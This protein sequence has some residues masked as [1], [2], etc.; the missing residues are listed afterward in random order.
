MKRVVGAAA[1]AAAV[2]AGFLRLRGRR[3]PEPELGPSHADELRARLDEARV[4]EAS[5]AV[6]EPAEEEPAAAGSA[7]SELDERRSAVHERAR[8]AIDELR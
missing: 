1:A 3:R 2:V 5:E 8:R 4:A 6:P 7:T